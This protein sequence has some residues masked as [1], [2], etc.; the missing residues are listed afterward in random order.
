METLIFLILSVSIGYLVNKLERIE[1]KLNDLE[2][3]LLLFKAKLPRRKS[4]EPDV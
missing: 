2:N 1:N 4:D 3:D